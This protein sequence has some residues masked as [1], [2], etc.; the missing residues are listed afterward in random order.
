MI[1]ETTGKSILAKGNEMT[2]GDGIERIL[3]PETL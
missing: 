3:A 1:F 2:F